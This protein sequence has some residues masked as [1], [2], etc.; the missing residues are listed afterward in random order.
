MLAGVVLWLVLRPS[1]PQSAAEDY[2]AALSR[3][4]AASALGLVVTDGL[5][6]SSAE[7][8]F[9]GVSGTISEARVTA[10]NE[11]GDTATAEIAY[12]LDAASASGEITLVRTDAGWKVTQSGLG[13]L[14]IASA[15]G[16]AAAIGT[17][18]VEVGAPFLLLPG[19]YDVLPAPVGILTGTATAG[20][21]PGGAATA[22]LQPEL[23]DTALET[24][25]AQVQAYIDAC[26]APTD[27]VPEGCGIRV[28]WAA[29]LA[30]LTSLAFRV[31]TAPTLAIAEDLSSF[32]ATGG[33]LVATATGTARDGSAGTFTYRTD[34]WSLRGGMDFTGNQLVLSVD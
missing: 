17:A 9:A 21:T 4:D 14:T 23:S 3:G 20:V 29:D 34:D 31:E 8:A 12:T 18:I 11:D 26:T 7:D 22:D 15:R 13:T 10:M 32:A 2:L 27:A 6:V 28:P 25:S 30:T 5:D 33:V 1:G 19:L 24:A 16:D